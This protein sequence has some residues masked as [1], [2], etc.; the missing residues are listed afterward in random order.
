MADLA[1][2]V[3]NVLPAANAQ[4]QQGIAGAAITQ[5]QALYLDTTTNTL[6]LADSNGSPPA[7]SIVGIA[8]NAAQIGQRI[9]YVGLDSAFQFGGTFTSFNGVYLSNT[10]GGLTETYADLASGS[11]VILVGMQ[12]STTK[13]N[14]SPVVGGTK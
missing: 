6:K 13:M 8:V 11:T 10:P 7:N 3:A 4:V 5:G 2:T 1:I 12:I 14:L 9:M